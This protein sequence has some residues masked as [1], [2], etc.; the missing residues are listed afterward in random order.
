MKLIGSN[1]EAQYRE[2]LV[3]SRDELFKKNCAPRLLEILRKNYPNL[4]S[5]F[6]LHWIPEQGE[7][8]YE[9]LINEDE[10]FTVEIP[11]VDAV[12][13]IIKTLPMNKF[14][15]QTRSKQKKIKLAV[16]LDLLRTGK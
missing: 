13:C 4:D 5:A 6:V 2:E 16:A 15:D 7:D 12:D 8:I 14:I 3:L 10:V 11:R 1:I 9:V